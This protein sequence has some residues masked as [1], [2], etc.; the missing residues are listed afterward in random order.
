MSPRDDAETTEQKIAHLKLVHSR[1]ER[2]LWFVI[3]RISN[4]CQNHELLL[5]QLRRRQWAVLAMTA[6]SLVLG[7]LNLVAK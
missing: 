3:D 5:T 2:E 6:S 7:I 1:T 4:Y